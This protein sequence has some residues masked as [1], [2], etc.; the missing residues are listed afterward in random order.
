MGQELYVGKLLPD[1]LVTEPV[2][3]VD[4]GGKHRHHRLIRNLFNFS[5]YH[6]SGLH[7]AAGVNQHDPP[8]TDHKHRII[9][10]SL[11]HRI[12]EVQG[13][14]DHIHIFRHFFCGI[15]NTDGS[16]LLLGLNTT[17]IEKEESRQDR[18]KVIF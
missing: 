7:A 13:A 4:V 1:G 3:S 15:R 9:H 6:P 10:K 18:D 12:G 8:F 14:V 2:V 5:Q 17:L 11:V 16:R